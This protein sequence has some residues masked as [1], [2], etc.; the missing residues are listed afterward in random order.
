MVFMAKQFPRNQIRAANK[1]LN[2]TRQ[3]LADSAVSQLPAR[4][5]ERRKMHQ[6]KLAEVLAP[7]ERGISIC[8]LHELSLE[9]TAST[10]RSLRLGPKPTSI[11]QGLRCT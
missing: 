9:K 7:L 1:F 11:K 3:T 4:R 2:A 5:T 10:V 6:S 8:I